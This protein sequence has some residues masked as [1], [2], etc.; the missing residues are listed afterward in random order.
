MTTAP[1]QP[2]IIRFPGGHAML[3]SFIQWRI[4]QSE[5]ELGVPLD[6]ARYV[7][8]VSTSAAMRLAR[9]SKI[10][11]AGKG[12]WMAVHIAS[13]V[14]AMAD[15]CG[16]CV[17]IGV[18]LARN[19]GVPRDVLAAVVERSP[20]RL[21][22]ELADVYRFATAVTE[23]SPEQEEYREAVRNRY[24][25]EGL[26]EIAMAIALH[27]VFPTLKRGLGFAKSCSLVRVDV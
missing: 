14:S 26:V 3:Q 17:Q 8:R 15:D 4:S 21:S 9:F 23:N 12:P 6:Y 10:L 11:A 2:I 27:R 5:R 24:G 13:I 25:D 16:S 18:N 1:I 19:A 22:D 7:A 20:E